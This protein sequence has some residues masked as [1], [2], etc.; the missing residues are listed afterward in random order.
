MKKVILFYCLALFFT[1]SSP[2]FAHPGNTDSNGCHTCRTNCAEKWGIPY[3]FYHRHNPVRPCLDEATQPLP[4]ATQ[5][6]LPTS[7]PMRLSTATSIP[8]QKPTVEPTTTNTPTPLHTIAPTEII[9]ITTTES[10]KPTA[11]ATNTITPQPIKTET[12]KTDFRWHTH[13]WNFSPL[14][15]LFGTMFGWK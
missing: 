8:T 15:S 1:I 12:I 2:V 11:S 9:T 4:T 14:T 6:P 13:W 10:Q 3:G 5:R 7:T